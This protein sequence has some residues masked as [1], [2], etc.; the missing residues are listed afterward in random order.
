M[1]QSCGV[2][3]TLRSPVSSLFLVCDDSIARFTPSLFG[4]PRHVSGPQAAQIGRAAAVVVRAAPDRAT[5]GVAPPS[6][7]PIRHVTRD[8]GFDPRTDVTP[9][10]MSARRTT[11]RCPRGIALRTLAP[12]HVL[13]CVWTGQ[14]LNAATLDIDHCLPWAAWSCSD[15]WNLVPAHRRVTST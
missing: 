8:L 14:R 4:D 2:R 1:R 10:S 11:W 6:F 15:L 5:F 9:I 7:V 13:H 3:C 12:G